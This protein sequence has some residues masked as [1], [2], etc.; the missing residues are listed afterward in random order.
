MLF[1]ASKFVGFLQPLIYGTGIL[2]DIPAQPC[3]PTQFP[4]TICDFVNLSVQFR[5][6]ALLHFSPLLPVQYAA[7][8]G[9]FLNFLKDFLLHGGQ[10]FHRLDF[11][12]PQKRA[13]FSIPVKTK[14]IF[15][16]QIIEP[17]GAVPRSSAAQ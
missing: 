11:V 8:F 16:Q 13:L 17:A 4:Q 14:Q 2:P 3:L 5:C 7:L 15:P 6:S 1:L 10:L 9:Q 12:F